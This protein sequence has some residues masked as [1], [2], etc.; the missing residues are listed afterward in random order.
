MVESRLIESNGNA[1]R[2][3]LAQKNSY[4]DNSPQQCVGK[5]PLE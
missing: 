5:F 2:E 4:S 3:T 1:L